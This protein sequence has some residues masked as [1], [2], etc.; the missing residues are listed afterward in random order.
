MRINTQLVP[1][2]E[3]LGQQE[4]V[5]GINSKYSILVYCHPV[6]LWIVNVLLIASDNNGGLR[7][8]L[9][10][11]ISAILVDRI[12]SLLALVFS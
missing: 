1:C 11:F 4:S 3:Y 7:Q 6:K 10:S 9:M 5:F 12:N 2:I 8:R